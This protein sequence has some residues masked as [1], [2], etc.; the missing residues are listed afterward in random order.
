MQTSATHR[1]VF[2][3][4]IRAFLKELMK[5]FP[6]ERDIKLLSSSL[7]ISLMDDP[8]NTVVS[9]FY[10]SFCSCESYIETQDERMF[11]DSVIRSDLE[12]LQKLSQYWEQLDTENK[13][14]VWD[15]LKVLYQLSKSILHVQNK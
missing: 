1:D 5:V 11:Y 9:K 10:H 6:N 8:E 2:H 4:E 13:Q 3:R 14:V 7:T 12:L 15:Y